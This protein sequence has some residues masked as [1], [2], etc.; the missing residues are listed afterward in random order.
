VATSVTELY[1]K[2]TMTKG[3][4]LILFFTLNMTPGLN[5]NWVEVYGLR[6]NTLT[7][8]STGSFR[9]TTNYNTKNLRYLLSFVSHAYIK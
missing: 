9:F 1:Y 3:Q 4:S 5:F 7:N 2:S 8:S 6:E